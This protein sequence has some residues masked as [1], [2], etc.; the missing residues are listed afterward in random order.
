VTDSFGAIEA[1]MAPVMDEI[2]IGGRDVSTL[3]QV[4]DQINDLL[5]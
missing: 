3:T 4:N 2:Y 5:K 1:L